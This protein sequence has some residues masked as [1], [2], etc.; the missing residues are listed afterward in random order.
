MERQLTMLVREKLKEELPC[1]RFHNVP[2]PNNPIGQKG[3]PTCGPSEGLEKVMC[4][5]LS[6]ETDKREAYTSP[7]GSEAGTSVVD[8]YGCGFSEPSV[9]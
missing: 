2:G 3:M 5:Y 1:S 6:M 7:L 8:C 4:P 9:N